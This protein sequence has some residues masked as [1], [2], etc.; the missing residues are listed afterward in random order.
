[1]K[2]IFRPHRSF[3]VFL[4]REQHASLCFS[5]RSEPLSSSSS[6]RQ[7]LPETGSP[8][9]SNEHRRRHVI[10]PEQ[11]ES[12][13]ETCRGTLQSSDWSTG[14]NFRAAQ[15]SFLNLS[16]YW[17]LQVMFLLL[18]INLINHPVL[19]KSLNIL[20]QKGTSSWVWTAKKIK[21]CEAIW[22]KQI[23]RR[24]PVSSS[25][26]VFLSR[27]SFRELGRRVLVRC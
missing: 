12:N 2:R 5:N 26:S 21:N 11:K 7:H 6:N 17:W 22:Q 8:L 19:L 13:M 16:T 23:C 4:Q 25:L 18:I 15:V 24:G 14:I 1:M 27:M 3:G 20:K 9:N 10:T